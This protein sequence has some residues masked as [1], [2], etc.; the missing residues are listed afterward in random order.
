MRYAFQQQSLYY[1]HIV[2]QSISFL[3]TFLHINLIPLSVPLNILS[4][5][6][7]FPIFK[8]FFYP[9]LDVV[10]AAYCE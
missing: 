3:Y 1:I 5:F 10:D 4:F 8:L 7:L 6:V 9:F 2:L